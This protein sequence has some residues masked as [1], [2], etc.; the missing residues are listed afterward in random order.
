M[1]K[2]IDIESI[3]NIIEVEPS[4]IN[5]VNKGIQE[6]L[7]L[8]AT[9]IASLSHNKKPDYQHLNQILRD[10]EGLSD[11]LFMGQKV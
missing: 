7:L 11:E 3:I 1:A 9:N 10:C 8:F 4:D 2:L 5:R 6:K